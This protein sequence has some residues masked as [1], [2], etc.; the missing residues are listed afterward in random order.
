MKQWTQ[1]SLLTL[2]IQL[3]LTAVMAWAADVK[4]VVFDTYNG[5]FV[6]NKFEP[7]QPA[8]FVVIR[9]QKAFDAV[10]GAGFVMGDKSH[11]LP[12]NA[13]DSKMVLAAIKR[14]KAICDFKVVEVIVDQGIVTLKYNVKSSPQAG[15]DYACPLIVSIP[16]SGYSAVRF[17]EDGQ[18]VKGIAFPQP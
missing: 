14:G 3:A 4:A 15:A 2:L 13:F 6:S 1:L 9:D 17:V 7:D 18:L 5:Y 16:R 11:R 12:D 10:F 8:S